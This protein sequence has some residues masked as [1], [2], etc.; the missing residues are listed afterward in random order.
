MDTYRL[1]GRWVCVWEEIRDCSI[2]CPKYLQFL[3][4]W[5]LWY[6]AQQVL[7]YS[8]NLSCIY[9]T[10]H[11]DAGRKKTTLNCFQ[12]GFWSPE[13][14]WCVSIGGM[15]QWMCHTLEHRGYCWDEIPRTA[16]NA[17]PTRTYCFA[18][19]DLVAS[20]GE[21]P[22]QHNTALKCARRNPILQNLYLQISS[23]ILSP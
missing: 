16:L 22:V 5:G 12:P 14:G 9:V 18:N 15:K 8:H 11:I 19:R 23:C 20:E 4:L 17:S 13:A 3:L 7:P 2:T 10:S 1:E 21:M 6:L